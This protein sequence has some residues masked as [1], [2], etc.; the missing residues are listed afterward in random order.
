METEKLYYADPFLTDFTATVL[1]CQ[2][3]KNGYLVTLDRTAFYPEGG[4]QPADHGVLDGAAVTDVHEKNGVIL[5]NVDRAVEIGKTV[6]GAIDWNRRFDFMQQ[7][8]GEHICSGLICER[9]HCDN[10]GFHM[11]A[12]IVTIDF[13]ADISWEE[14]L[15]IE[16]K[17][18]QY[19]YENHPIDIQ[20][21]RGAELEAI[22][23]RSKKALEGDVRIVAF[24]GADCCACCGTHVLRSGQVGLVKFLSVQK[25]REGVRIELLCGKRAL[26][27]LSKTWEQAKAIGTAIEELP[28]VMDA[29]FVSRDT[30]MDNFMS[31]YDDDM[32]VG[33]DATV[34][35]HRFVIHLND[36]SLMA[37]TQ[38]ELKNIDGI[39][40]VRAHLDYAKAFVTIRNIVSVVSLILIVILVFVSVFIMSNTIKLATFG[41]REE[42]AIM[43]MVGASNAFIRLPFIVEGLVLGMLGGGLAFLAEWGLYNLVTGKIVTS[44]TGNLISVIPFSSVSLTVF[45]VYMATGILVGAF[46]G[47]NAIKNY[48]K[49]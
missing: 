20:F 41:R 22:D 1:D 14:L 18:N 16:A 49:V 34:F 45:I 33:I 2:P 42:I 30:A 19:L 23:Y 7:H 27:Y 47:V 29:E 35:K 46:G 13:N 21:H 15:E 38:N 11:G 3:G 10:V 8:S 39:V 37:Q 6:A 40:K 28:N 5:H 17:A 31:N 44:L 24:P 48:L 36:I 43:K 32:M 25:F 9:F 12:D 26:E 4:G